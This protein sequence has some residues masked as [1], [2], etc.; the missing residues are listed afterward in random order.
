MESLEFSLGGIKPPWQDR[1]RSLLVSPSHDHLKEFDFFSGFGLVD[2]SSTDW[3]QIELGFFKPFEGVALSEPAQCGVISFEGQNFPVVPPKSWIGFSNGYIESVEPLRIRMSSDS[4]L[5]FI[6]EHCPNMAFSACHLF[7]GAVCGWERALQWLQKQSLLCVDTTIAVDSD[8]MVMKVWEL[9]HSFDGPFPK[10]HFGKIPFSNSLEAINGVVLPVGDFS[11][12]NLC[13]VMVNLIFTLSPP[14]QTWSTG[15]RMYGFEH[16]NGFALAEGIEG[17]KRIRPLVVCF[18]CSDNILKHPQYELVKKLLMFCGYRQAWTSN[19]TLHNLA[20]MFRTR[21][22]AVWVRHDVSHFSFQSIESFG[23]VNSE[24]WDHRKYDFTIP[25]QLEHQLKLGSS[26]C[27]IYGDLRLLPTNKRSGLGPSPTP[28]SVLDARCLNKGE[29]MPTVVASYSRQHEIASDHVAERGIFAFLIKNAVGF[30]FI[31]PFKCLALL[32]VPKDQCAFVP[33]KID[34]AFRH[35]GNALSV[36]QALLCLLIACQSVGINFGPLRKVILDCWGNRLTANNCIVFRTK[37]FFVLSP[38]KILD[39]FFADQGPL[40][41]DDGFPFWASLPSGEV[42]CFFYQMTFKELIVAF[43]FEKPHEQGLVCGHHQGEFNM[44]EKAASFIGCEI[45][46]RFKGVDLLRFVVHKKANES[47]PISPT[48]PFTIRDA[49]DSPNDEQVLPKQTNI[50]AAIFDHEIEHRVVI[51]VL[52]A[53]EP[54]H[55]TWKG[56]LSPDVV[57]SLLRHEVCVPG[58][59]GFVQWVEARITPEDDDSLRIFLVEIAPDFPL[60][61]LIRV[62]HSGENRHCVVGV[63]TVM[64]PIQI[65]LAIQVACESAFVNGVATHL[66]N[67]ISFKSGDCIQFKLSNFGFISE[68]SKAKISKRI[69]NLQHQGS[70]LAIDEMLFCRRIHNAKNPNFTLCDV[71]L[72][73]EHNIYDGR[74]LGVVRKSFMHFQLEPEKSF[75]LPF[76][77]E[78]HWCAIEVHSE[79]I[80]AL[81]FPIHHHDRIKK[82]FAFFV[83]DRAGQMAIRFENNRLHGLCGWSLLQR[84]FAFSDAHFPTLPVDACFDFIGQTQATMLERIPFAVIDEAIPIADFAIAARNAFIVAVQ[85]THTAF[86]I[87]WI[88][89]FG[90]SPPCGGM[91]VDSATTGSNVDMIFLADPWAKDR[92]QCRWQD[93]RLPKDH[94]FV[95]EDGKP[96]FQV[97]RQKMGPNMGGVAF[98]TRSCIPEIIKASPKEPAAIILPMTEKEVKI[99]MIVQP[100]IQGPYEVVV[101]D[102]S[103]GAVYKRQVQ[104]VEITQGIKYVLPKPEYEAKLSEVREIVLEIDTRL[105]SK[106][107][108]TSLQEKP[109]EIFRSKIH[110]QFPPNTFKSSNLYGYRKFTP[111]SSNEDHCIH[112]IMCKLPLAARQ[113]VLGRSGVG[114]MTVRDFVPRGGSIDDITTIP[115]FWPVD[116]QSK[117]DALRTASG[118][119]GFMGLVVTKRGLAARC[120]TEKIAILR[121]ALMPMDERIIDLNENTVPRVIVE[122]TGWPMAISP[123]EVVRATHHAVKKAPIPMRCYRSFGVTS[124]SLAF[125]TLPQLL[126]FTAKFNDEVCEILLTQSKQPKTKAPRVFG[127][128]APAPRVSQQS[129]SVAPVHDDDTADRLGALESKVANMEKRQ[130]ALETRISTGFDS[131]SDQLRQVLNA[132]QQRPKSPTGDTPQPKWPKVGA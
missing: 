20:R 94:P 4:K 54:I 39:F 97:H 10:M 109:V 51:L 75:A 112:Q 132:V 37:E 11:W 111:K 52:G 129:V 127:K 105:V 74:F 1:I 70:E 31:D 21:W 108:V 125:D 42:I 72:L 57:E 28:E 69:Q 96:A 6:S 113:I 93:L 89:S 85:T 130:D 16:P 9:Q 98:A 30:S 126:K 12:M 2:S 121:K 32:G 73:H 92:K 63:S 38:P 88:S 44:N 45:T 61:V 53:T 60:K 115:R 36:Q 77:L 86:G 48:L 43:G 106:D 123:E 110:D 87:A 71:E 124:W 49:S 122:S 27:A 114:I 59:K 62:L 5:W 80:V 103:T 64:T 65:A 29:I 116:R 107:L 104:L 68:N 47:V 22:L 46:L 131:V 15:G 78:K 25:S 79:S 100:K 99:D 66:L 19:T 40:N 24:T 8:E 76:L 26:L 128:Q 33:R 34:V 58:S 120:S 117:D 14:C 119:D 35:I 118:L 50:T 91:E 95:L 18:E 101:E 55:T 82:L 102:S 81:G 83:S 90:T 3:L 56:L 13:R 41:S 84:W 17:I 7:A 67:P 23:C